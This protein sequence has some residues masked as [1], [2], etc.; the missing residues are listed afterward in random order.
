MKKLLVLIAVVAAIFAFVDVTYAGNAYGKTKIHTN[1]GNHYGQL[2][3]KSNKGKHL[4]QIKH[5]PPP[6]VV[7]PAPEPPVD[8]VVQ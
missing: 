7:E 4:G 5:A 3:V 1:R 6:P 2:K 8:P